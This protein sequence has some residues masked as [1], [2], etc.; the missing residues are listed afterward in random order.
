MHLHLASVVFI[1]GFH[2]F[3][4][5]FVIV[6]SCLSPGWLTA[7]M[8]WGRPWTSV[9]RRSPSSRFTIASF[10]LSPLSALFYFLH[11][12]V[13]F[14]WDKEPHLIISSGW[15][16]PSAFGKLRGQRSDSCFEV[17]FQSNSKSS[18]F[19]HN[20]EHPDQILTR[21]PKFLCMGVF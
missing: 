16:V 13:T 20:H 2:V 6:C 18:K 17:I 21:S 15:P 19:S 1:T 10:L 3:L 12:R 14:F 9:S 11:T 7:K 4:L 5:V 8:V